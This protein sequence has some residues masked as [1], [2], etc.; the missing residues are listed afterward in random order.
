MQAGSLRKWLSPLIAD[1]TLWGTPM[2]AHPKSLLDLSL[3]LC[4]H[5]LRRPKE[6]IQVGKYTAEVLLLAGLVLL[7]EQVLGKWSSRYQT[8]RGYRRGGNAT[9]STASNR[10]LRLIWVPPQSHPTEARS[11]ILLSSLPRIFP[12]TMCCEDLFRNIGSDLREGKNNSCSPGEECGD[13]GLGFGT[14]QTPAISCVTSTNYS[15]LLSPISSRGF[16]QQTSEPIEREQSDG[17]SP[18]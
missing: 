17:S 10:I 13:A 2:W 18:L 4:K 12:F 9:I 8:N 11:I 1:K 5:R 14:I 3:R 16:Q 6:E 15:N 7:G